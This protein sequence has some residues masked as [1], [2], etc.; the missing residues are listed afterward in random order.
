MKYKTEIWI[1]YNY[2]GWSLIYSKVF[3]LPF[4]PFIGLGIIFDDKEYEITLENNDYCTTEISY[5]LEKKQFE[6]N[7]RH[8][9]KHLVREETIDSIIKKYS[10][11]EN[12][13]NDIDKLK[14]L[15]RQSQI[16]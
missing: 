11:W 9:W 8:T 1:S 6:V 13:H 14:E 7:V 3:D 10:N 2:G 12:Q 5:N 15:I 16:G 4:V